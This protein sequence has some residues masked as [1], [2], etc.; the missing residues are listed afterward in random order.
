MSYIALYR[1]FRPDSFDEVKG[2]EHIVTTLQ[3]QLRAGRVGHAYLFCGTRGTGKTTMAK[4]LAKTVNCENPTE[5]GPCGK[6]PSCKAIADGSSLNVIEIDAASNNGVDNI[7]QINEAVQYSPAQGKYLVYII[8]EVHMLSAGAYNALLKTLE[9]PPEYV[10]FILATTDEHKLP[11]TIKS[12][13]Q[14][15]DFHRIPLETI[16][17]RLVEIVDR[18]GGDATRDALKFIAR[19]ADGSMRDALS[20]LDECMSASLG[21]TLDRESVLKT[22]GA[23]SVDIYIEL[24]KSIKSDDA[25]RV[26]DIINESI[27]NGKDLT[28]FV[29][30]FT[31]FMRNVLFLKLSPGISKELDMTEE[32][33]EELI[34]LGK[35]FSAE[36]LTRYLNILQ[37]LCSDIRASSV[38]RVTLEMALIRMMRP[39]SD[40][41]L[42]SVI[43][44]LER[45]ES[46]GVGTGQVVARQESVAIS[47]DTESSASSGQSR[48]GTGISDSEIQDLVKNLVHKEIEERIGDC[49]FD[50]AKPNVDKK[51][52]SDIVLKNIRE[53]F[54][55]ATADDI[56]DLAR[57]WYRDIVPKLSGL[58][59]EYANQISVEPSP[60][61]QLEGPA[62]LRIIFDENDKEN[63]RYIYFTIDKNRSEFADELS[64]IIGKN[65]ELEV[66]T[67]KGVKDTLDKDSFAFDKIDFDNIKFID[68][69]E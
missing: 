38:K 9:E 26:L 19:T 48:A 1:K 58:K 42:S 45:L 16:T 34:E 54:P 57:K 10:I 51:K 49:T 29:D 22:I 24:V 56:M 40:I 46:A 32:N 21:S 47:S 4:L 63:N 33:A 43:G 61:Y 30:D 23:V 35:A 18:E 65:V 7:R 3:N 6:C 31:W 15:Y 39:E 64:Q 11:V 25:L 59:K 14:R 53:K 5:N 67:R 62:R 36:T 44:R 17:D 52:Q 2:Q 37:E 12:R 55:P 28:K 41:D 69:E 68:S 20:I 50:N 8:D 60:E 66:V 13:C 27:Y